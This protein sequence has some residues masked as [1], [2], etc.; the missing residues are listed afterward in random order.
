MITSSKEYSQI[1]D[2]LK[3][4]PRGMSLKQISHAIGMN[5]ISAA[6][7][8]DVL[9]TSGQVDMVPYGQTKLFFLSKSAPISALLDFSSDYVLLLSPDFR[10]RQINKKFLDFFEYELD[11][12]LGKPVGN[13]FYSIAEDI[14]I[15]KMIDLA[16][17]GQNMDREIRI[18]KAEEEF[19]FKIKIIPTVFY[20]GSPGT[21]IIFND[22]TEYKRSI[23]ALIESQEKYIS[24]IE[25]ISIL[26]ESVEAGAS[27]NDHIRNPLQAIVGLAEIEGGDQMNKIQTLVEDIDKM[28]KELDI[29]WVESTNLRQVIN[30][31]LR[32]IDEKQYLIDTTE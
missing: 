2:T 29:G 31:A 25:K 5:R 7:Y 30:K 13:V 3:T 21:T 4:N 8:L 17:S 9:R 16:L 15:E 28:V 26:L 32:Y 12:I 27:L 22:I 18:L 23:A 20:D 6:R 24:L 14:P 10:I 1:I 19:F 11:E